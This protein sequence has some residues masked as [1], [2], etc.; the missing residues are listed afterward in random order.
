LF[1]LDYS[2]AAQIQYYAGAPAYTSWGQ[3]RIWGI[4]EFDGATVV[5]L[6][7]VS[8]DQVSARLRQAFR[9][10]TGPERLRYAERGVTKDVRIWQAEGLQLDQEAFL[11]RFDFLTLLEASR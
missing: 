11:Q 5:A 1:A 3:Y 7:Y 10:V 9:R 8:Q 6:D 2:I 4:P